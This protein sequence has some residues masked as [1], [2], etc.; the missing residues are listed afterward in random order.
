MIVQWFQAEGRPVSCSASHFKPAQATQRRIFR[1]MRQTQ[2]GA[3][4]NVQL[5]AL[6]L[7]WDGLKNWANVLKAI[8]LRKKVNNAQFS[9]Y[10]SVLNVSEN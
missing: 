9:T 7:S 6:F 8:L 4:E 1:K 5:S 10:K 2:S 3:T